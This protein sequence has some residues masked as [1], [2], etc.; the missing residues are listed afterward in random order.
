VIAQLRAFYSQVD[1]DHHALWLGDGD[2]FNVLTGEAWD[3]IS[4]YATLAP[5]RPHVLSCGSAV[6]FREEWGSL[7]CGC[8][9]EEECPSLGCA[10]L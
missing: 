4:P 7:P 5:S 10:S 9:Y 2:D 3:G 8:L 1:P 6:P